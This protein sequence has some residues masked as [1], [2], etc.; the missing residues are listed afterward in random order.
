MAKKILCIGDVILDIIPSIFPIEK[1]KILS[2]GE[3]FIDS[4]TFQKGG[5]AANFS[6][7]FKSIVPEAAV[8]LISRVG[9]QPYSDFLLADIRKYGVE[10]IFTI[11]PHVNTQITIAPA[12]QDGQRHFLT[13]LGGLKDF[14]IQ[15]LPTDLFLGVD[16]LAFRGIWFAEKLLLEAETFL[17]KA[18]AHGIDVSMDLGFDPYWNLTDV[19]QAHTEALELRRSA[20]F[21]ILK[22]I[23]F[24]FGNEEEFLRLTDTSTLE[25]AIYEL[26]NKGIRNIIIHRGHKGCRI[27]KPYSADPAQAVK[28]IDI[29]ALHVEVVNPVGSGDTF[30]SILIA[31]VMAGKSLI[32]AAAMAT[33]GAAYALMHPAGTVITLE[34]VEQFAHNASEL[35]GFIE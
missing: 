34:I 33:A 25:E 11:D 10:P 35:R 19:D 26:V 13:Y 15:D 1:T 6:C 28:T 29:P 31:Q 30:D 21:K 20:A 14:S 4:V 27:I 7:V 22:Y 17:Q 3:T 23:K 5:C 18:M 9:Q 24:L 16:H 8:V 12:Y 32:Q 2:D